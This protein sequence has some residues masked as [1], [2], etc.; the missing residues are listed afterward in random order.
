[1][2]VLLVDDSKAMRMVEKQALKELNVNDILE[3]DNGLQAIEQL[4]TH[5]ADIQ[6]ILLDWNMPEMDGF[7]FLKG[8][9][10][11][12]HL[13]NIPVIM[14]TTEGTKD[15]FVQAGEIG[16]QGYVIKPFSVGQLQE[17][18]KAVAPGLG[19]NGSGSA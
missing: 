1:M 5:G 16:V 12:P 11:V 8:L 6:L 10:R 4:K 9:R 19:V 3:A 17:R 2:A 14:V 7:T 13:K 18:V 15:K